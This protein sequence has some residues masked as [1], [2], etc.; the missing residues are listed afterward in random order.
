MI[1]FT[2]PLQTN[3]TKLN[4]KLLP[5]NCYIFNNN[6]MGVFSLITESSTLLLN[7]LQSLYM[8][9]SF[10]FILIKKMKMFV[11]FDDLELSSHKYLTF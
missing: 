3:E 8:K 2:N 4:D 10:H 11:H 6:T 1:N 9:S 7:T 5:S